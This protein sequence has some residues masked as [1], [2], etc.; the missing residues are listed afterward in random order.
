MTLEEMTPR[1]RAAIRKISEVYV[2]Y[3]EGEMVRRLENGDPLALE[4]VDAIM[5]DNFHRGWPTGGP[6]PGRLSFVDV[7]EEISR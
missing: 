5:V 3:F 6:V 7:E 4:L 1:Q 2:D